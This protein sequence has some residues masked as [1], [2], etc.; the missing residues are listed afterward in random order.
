MANSVS[1]DGYLHVEGYE[2]FDRQA[3]NM[4]K[5][6]AG[7]R[8]VGQLITGRAQMNLALAR[9]RINYPTNRT[10][11]LLDSIKYRVSRAGF[12]VR[13]SPT[14]TQGMEAFYP[15]YLHYGVRLGSRVKGRGAGQGRRARGERQALVAARAQKGWRIAPRDNYMTDALTDSRAEVQRILAATF[16]SALLDN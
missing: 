7:M 12:L 15:A 6:R 4:R 9:G 1:V 3:F 10:G 5:V 2:A 8:K 11:E 16:A 14:M 13:I